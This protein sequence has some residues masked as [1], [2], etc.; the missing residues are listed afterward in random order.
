MVQVFHTLDL[1]GVDRRREH[2]PEGDCFFQLELRDF[3]CGWRRRHSRR[4]GSGRLGDDVTEGEVFRRGA[5][6]LVERGVIIVAGDIRL[7]VL[8]VAVGAIHPTEAGAA[9]KHVQADGIAL[10]QHP[11]QIGGLVGRVGLAV[12]AAPVIEP[13]VPVL[14]VKERAVGADFFQ[15]GETSLC[16]PG[17]GAAKVDSD[18]QVGK[19]ARGNLLRSVGR[20]KHGLGEPRIHQHAAGL[21]HVGVIIA[22]GAVFVFH[23]DQNDGAAF[24]DLQRRELLA[25]ALEPAGGGLKEF[26]IAAANDDGM[27][28]QKP[29]GISAELP[30]GAGI[31]AGAQDDVQAFLLRFA[32]EFGDVVAAGE[33]VIAGAGFMRVPENIGGDGVESHGLG[34][35]KTVTPVGARD[36]RVVHLTGND[37]EGFAIEKKLAVVYGEASGHGMLLRRRS[38]RKNCQGDKE[39]K[40]QPLGVHDPQFAPVK[41]SC[42]VLCVLL[43]LRTP[44]CGGRG[45]SF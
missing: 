8:A 27:I 36:A 9:V 45:A 38:G 5:A 22:E 41:A 7:V 28:F 14:A 1:F 4:R 18:G 24:V 12:F 42:Q 30:L 31:G 21:L 32:N 11:V 34:H 37:L 17:I 10:A 6:T 43:P 2:T 40:A 23:L 33:I 39:E 29:G 3:R 26:R 35:A 15:N 19:R 25:E 13:A 20:I 44:R 16:R